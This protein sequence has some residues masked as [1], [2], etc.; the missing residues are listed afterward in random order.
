M[1]GPSGRLRTVL[2]L[3]VVLATAVGV[4][5]LA[6]D[7]RSEARRE[8]QREAAVAAAR[9]AAVALTSLD[10]A[11]ADAGVDR[12]L[13]L[14]TGDLAQQFDDS[15]DRLRT[16]LGSRRSRSEGTV[17]EA[18]LASFTGAEAEVLVAVD[19]SVT[20]ADTTAPRVQRYR[21]A[22]TVRRVGDGWRA[23]RV[24]FAGAPAEGVL[25]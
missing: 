1:R 17:L 15:R 7:V 2:L 25:P 23:E 10:H 5:V 13:A 3:L 24:L 21:M 9:E 18:G 6:L 11:D 14:A 8:T 19:A 22:L 12:V 4:A 20:D 16:L